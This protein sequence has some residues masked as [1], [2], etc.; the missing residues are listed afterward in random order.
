MSNKNDT[1][2]TWNS[3]GRLAERALIQAYSNHKLADD[4]QTLFKRIRELERE[5]ELQWRESAKN[6]N[7]FRH[8]VWSLKPSIPDLEFEFSRLGG[9]YESYQQGEHNYVLAVLED[10]QKYS[11]QP[12][13]CVE[14][15]YSLV[16][17]ADVSFKS[18]LPSDWQ[19]IEKSLCFRSSDGVGWSR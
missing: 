2:V 18:S 6:W 17:L 8:R 19:K 16:R 13:P 7:R 3:L 5:N 10:C 9:L 15:F 14:Q 4:Q 12:A 1:V 11:T